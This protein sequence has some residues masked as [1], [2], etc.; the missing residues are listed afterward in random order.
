MSAHKNSKLQI[1]HILSI[2]D[3]RRLAIKE[4]AELTGINRRNISPAVDLLK[5][6]KLVNSDRNQMKQNPEAGSYRMVGLSDQFLARIR[7]ICRK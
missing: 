4:L 7:Q 1:L 6:M 3:P 2:T 5:K